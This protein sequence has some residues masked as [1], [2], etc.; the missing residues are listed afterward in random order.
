[1]ESYICIEIFFLGSDTLLQR[2]ATHLSGIF[3]GIFSTIEKDTTKSLGLRGIR[4]PEPTSRLQ[5]NREEANSNGGTMAANF[6]DL[7]KK[8]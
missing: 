1:M 5:S 2:A 3:H 6:E 7:K 8:S 4:I